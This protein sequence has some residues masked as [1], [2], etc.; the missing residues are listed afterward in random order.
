MSWCWLVWQVCCLISCTH[1]VFTKPLLFQSCSLRQLF[2]PPQINDQQ[3]WSWHIFPCLLCIT[4]VRCILPT[5]SQHLLNEWIMKHAGFICAC[6]GVRVLL[7][8]NQADWHL[9]P[10]ETPQIRTAPHGCPSHTK[11]NFSISCFKSV[12]S[13]LAFWVPESSITARRGW[14][15]M[16]TPGSVSTVM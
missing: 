9:A 1:W 10:I 16:L 4:W 2:C 7:Y 6:I 3:S 11:P 15:V 13:F 8:S 12:S 5:C 14:N